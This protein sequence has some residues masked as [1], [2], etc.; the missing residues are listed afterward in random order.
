MKSILL[1][2]REIREKCLINSCFSTYNLQNTKFNKLP[3]WLI[4]TFLLQNSF[5]YRPRKWIW[6][7]VAL[8][9]EKKFH[10]Q[11]EVRG[12]ACW[13]WQRRSLHQRWS[14]GANVIKLFM[15]VIYYCGISV[16]FCNKRLSV[17]SLSS[18]P[19]SPTFDVKLLSESVV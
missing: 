11:P 14:P 6:K 9:V 19:W 1:K 2:N 18:I 10:L 17:I 5:K 16:K 12:E 4:V 8:R 3:I 13:Q 7:W 15:C